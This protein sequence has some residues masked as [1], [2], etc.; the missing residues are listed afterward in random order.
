MLCPAIPSLLPLAQRGRRAMFAHFSRYTYMSPDGCPHTLPQ[1][2]HTTCTFHTPFHTLQAPHSLH[3][4][5]ETMIWHDPDH[6][7]LPSVELM[8]TLFHPGQCGDSSKAE[9]G[10]SRK[11]SSNQSAYCLY[12]HCSPYFDTS[13]LWDSL[14]RRRKMQQKLP[15]I[16]FFSIG[17]SVC[18]QQW[19]RNRHQPLVCLAAS[20]V[21]LQPAW[22]CHG[23]ET[24]RRRTVQQ[25]LTMF[26]FSGG[27]WTGT[28]YETHPVYPYIYLLMLSL[29]I[30][31]FQVV[32]S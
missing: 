14:R 1:H 18:G 22:T 6:L 25:L 11:V 26:F 30:S 17:R 20:T 19:S 28:S 32:G 2:F 29:Q 3:C 31:Y 27:R 8:H 23:W 21:T 12:F 24:R 10:P 5:I 7:C 16:F 15:V 4:Q 13:Q 9:A